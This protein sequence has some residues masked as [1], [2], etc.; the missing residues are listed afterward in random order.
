MGFSALGDCKDK[1]GGFYIETQLKK[2]IL[3]PTVILFVIEEEV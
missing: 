2:C 1:K 3:V